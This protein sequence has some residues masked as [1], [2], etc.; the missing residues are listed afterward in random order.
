[1]T[2]WWE[3]SGLVQDNTLVELDVYKLLVNAP[4][5]AKH[6]L[7]G[8]F[9]MIL[10]WNNDPLLPRAM[11][12][13][14]FNKKTG[15]VTIIYRVVGLGT[16]ALTRLRYGDSL[17]VIGPLGTPFTAFGQTIAVVGRGVGITPL[18]PIA[19]SAHHQGA[20]VHSYLSARSPKLI[21]NVANFN[22]VGPVF[23]H[24]DQ[25]HRG[26]LI[27]NLLEAH[28]REGFRPNTV[29]VAGSHRLASAVD[30]LR[31]TYGFAAWIF[32]EEKMACGVGYCKGCAVGPHQSLICTKGPALLSHEVLTHD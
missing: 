28:L 8:Q 9:L 31:H 14:R 18:L 25:T 21:L 30:Q 3:E 2:Q 5:I 26:Q 6:A 27:T 23:T 12:P 20:I 19:E 15:M 22:E 13:I 1:M 11:A 29:V 17:T 7:P 24:N 10:G 32:V 16:Q 4:I